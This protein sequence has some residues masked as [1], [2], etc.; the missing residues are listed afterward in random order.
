MNETLC[1]KTDGKPAFPQFHDEGGRQKGGP[2]EGSARG[3][4]W[5]GIT[6]PVPKSIHVESYLGSSKVSTLLMLFLIV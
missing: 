6:D 5:G 4:I 3:A 2:W 1:L